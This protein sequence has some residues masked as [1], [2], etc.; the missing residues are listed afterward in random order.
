MRGVALQGFDQC[1]LVTGKVQVG[2]GKVFLVQCHSLMTST[3][4]VP[5]LQWLYDPSLVS[6][7]FLRGLV[8]SQVIVSQIFVMGQNEIAAR[9]AMPIHL[10]L[11]AEEMTKIRPLFVW[12]AVPLVFG[13]QNIPMQPTHGVSWRVADK[14]SQCPHCSVR[15]TSATTFRSARTNARALPL[16]TSSVHFP[17]GKNIRLKPK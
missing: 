16:H 17:S 5:A 12:I 6:Q 10:R 2:H 13:C 14:Q 9:A 7:D 3:P 15:A 11:A 1:F 4:A 8:C